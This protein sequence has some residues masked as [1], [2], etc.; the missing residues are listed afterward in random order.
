M[1]CKK[2][3]VC[4]F[5]EQSINC[6]SFSWPSLSRF[7]LC[8]RGKPFQM[9]CISGMYFDEDRKQCDYAQ[10]VK[11]LADGANPDANAM[12]RCSPQGIY[13]MP[14]PYKC[15]NFLMCMDGIQTIQQCDAF[16]RFDVMSQA[17]MVKDRATCILDVV[18][19]KQYFQ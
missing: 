6:L 7:H 17:C 3:T 16:H 4:A 10:N 12:P 13:S 19:P 9:R 2:V 11:C 8:Y 14:H 15:E 18:N 5:P 1:K